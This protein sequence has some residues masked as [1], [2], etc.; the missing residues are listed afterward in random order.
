MSASKPGSVTLRNTASNT[1][2]KPGSV[3]LRN[4]AS[5]TASKP[6]SNAG[7]ETD[8]PAAFPSTEN[9]ET[10]RKKDNDDNP[11]QFQLSLGRGGIGRHQP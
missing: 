6:G 11:Q 4:T 7:I 5:N 3:T 10:K 9:T 1:A 8:S 2:S